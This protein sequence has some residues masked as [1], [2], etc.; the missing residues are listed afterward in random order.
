MQRIDV[1]RYNEDV[2][3]MRLLQMAQRR[4]GGIRGSQRV[5]APP[6]VVERLH[7]GWITLERL[8][9]G[10]VLDA[11]FG[12]NA[13]TVTERRKAGFCRQAR[14]RQDYNV[15]ELSHRT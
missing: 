13:I 2:A 4:V 15:I 6:G 9:R 12:P 7:A 8:R 11:H 3:A 5:V 10:D 14:T 1:L